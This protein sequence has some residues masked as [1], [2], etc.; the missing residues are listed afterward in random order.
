MF[1]RECDQVLRSFLSCPLFSSKLTQN[2]EQL[3]SKAEAKGMGQ[4]LRQ[5]ERFIAALECL[6]RVAELPQGPGRVG[7]ATYPGI[8]RAITQ[9]ERPIALTLRIIEG[10][11]LFEMFPGGKEL[12][13][14]I[15]G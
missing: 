12:A 6:V 8:T 11:S 3:P 10:D 5:R 1:G 9:D 4:P 7:Q 2:A 15:R 14:P 13:H